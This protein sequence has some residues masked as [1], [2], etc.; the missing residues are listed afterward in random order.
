M[1]GLDSQGSRMD[2]RVS[3]SAY[4]FSKQCTYFM[5]SSFMAIVISLDI[6]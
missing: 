3:I 5:K 1:K 2:P 6:I 4:I